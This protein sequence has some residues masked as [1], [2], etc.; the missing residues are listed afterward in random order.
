[1]MKG[2]FSALFLMLALQM[3][4][5]QWQYGNSPSAQVWFKRGLERV[6]DQLWIGTYDNFGLYY[7]VDGYSWIQATFFPA[8]TD[9]YD[10][11]AINPDHV[12]LLTCE[13]G[14]NG[15]MTVYRLEKKGGSWG[16]TARYPLP[17]N[18]C[19][20]I[21]RVFQIGD[22]VVVNNESWGLLVGIEPDSSIAYS[23]PTQHFAHNNGLIVRS[24]GAPGA[25]KVALSENAGDSWAEVLQTGSQIKAVYADD[26]YVWAALSG[27]TLTRKNRLTGQVQNFTTPFS[28]ND[29]YLRFGKLGDTLTLATNFEWWY[30]INEG[31]NWQLLCG[32]WD[33]GE[34]YDVIEEIPE[35]PVIIAQGD[36][37][38]RSDDEGENWQTINPGIGAYSIVELE[39]NGLENCVFA[40]TDAPGQPLYRS[41]NNGQSWTALPTP[42]TG[43]QFNDMQ[44]MG[45]SSIFVLEN[46]SLYFSANNGDAWVQLSTAVDFP[47]TKLDGYNWKVFSQGLTAIQQYNVDGTYENILLPAPASQGN[48]ICDFSPGP[49]EW[50]LLMQNGDFYYS[51][52][53]GNNW[54][55]RSSAPFV[56]T[57]SRLT[58]SG[59]NLILWAN[60]LVLYSTD[61]GATWLPADFPGYLGYLLNDAT[62]STNTGAFAAFQNLGV[63]T[64]PDDGA[65][66]FPLTDGLHN[67]N[68]Y[69]L[70]ITNGKLFAGTHRG[71]QWNRSFITP[72]VRGMVFHD[73]N[74]NGAFNTGEP[75]LSQVVVEARASG[76]VATTDASGKFYFPYQ[77]GQHDTLFVAGLPVAAS[78]VAPAQWVVNQAGNNYRFAVQGWPSVD[79][80]AQLSAQHSFHTGESSQIQFAYNNAG[81]QT[82]ED[83]A[84]K[85]NLPAG[86]SLQTASPWPSQINGDTLVWWPGNLAAGAQ[87]FVQ[88]TVTVD[89]ALSAGS[90]LRFEGWVSSAS[91]EGQS[92]NNRHEL[93]ATVFESGQPDLAKEVDRQVVTPA[94]IAA[95]KSLEYTLRFRNDGSG[96]AHLLVIRDVLDPSLDATSFRI[97]GSSHPCVWNVTG[98]NELTISFPA[99]NLPPS[100][101]GQAASEGFVRFAVDVRP[102]LPP[103]TVI[104]NKAS[105]SFDLQQPYWSN[106]TETV[107]ELY[108]P[109]D[110][111]LDPDS[112]MGVRPNPAEYHLIADWN[113][114]ADAEGRIWLVDASGVVRVE[115]PLAIGQYTIELNVT[116]IP[117]GVYVVFV[118][119][120]TRHYVRTAVVQ[121]TNDPRRN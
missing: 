43:H 108:D 3:A 42:F 56:Q 100:W 84:L 5:A 68:V 121:H 51:T 14:N 47:G 97:V 101:Q 29:I 105:F 106:L 7:S 81:T 55:Y 64:S 22:R 117:S 76:W 32:Y 44:W 90:V 72:Y 28:L 109:N 94:E 89:P 60:N 92:A 15:N 36:N 113:L 58:R 69:S 53:E 35:W 85:L 24:Y 11:Y 87:G 99:I 114:P 38:I 26:T 96:T 4:H 63:Y 46:K 118:D 74:G 80:T 88:L 2:L 6:G 49:G 18:C 59:N 107:L 110:P 27:Q 119:A 91:P 102:G 16:I 78:A 120:G 13:R 103:G 33:P 45:A 12:L 98:A 82:A 57:P 61:K 65:T 48:P 37:M 62:A 86:T 9:I 34:A 77:P 40:G 20:N 23:T 71:G 39:R 115:E 19:S 10:I 17:V 8:S 1:M 31:Q 50:Y 41:Q 73:L 83:L 54:E 21:A 79:L 95:G 75:T 112:P 104:H 25:Y 111:Q 66:W 116:Y 30:S 67:R 52:D 70:L 93:Q